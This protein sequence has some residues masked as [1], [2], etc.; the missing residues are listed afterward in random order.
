MSMPRV[1]IASPIRQKPEILRVF[2]DS[3][4]RLHRNELRLSC[5]FIDDNLDPESSNLLSEFDIDGEYR[6]IRA[7]PSDSDDRYFQDEVQHH[8]KEGLVWK[9]AEFKDAFIKIAL[10]SNVDYLFLV[11]SD[12]VLNPR[13]LD[14][15]VRCNKEVISEVFW[16]SWRPEQMLLPQVWVSGTYDFVK[17][18]RDKGLSP[19]EVNRQ[20]IEFLSGLYRPGQRRVGGLGAC[21]LISRS[22]LHKGVSFAEI[23]N[24]T[25]WGEDRHFCV[26]ARALGVE[27]WADTTYPPLHLY[28]E[29]MLCEVEGFLNWSSRDHLSQ[30][31]VTLSMVV[32]NETGRYLERALRHH[33]DAIDAAVIIDDASDD[34]TVKLIREC[35]Q[36]VPLKIVSN[37][38]S[39]FKNEV[40]LR[41]KQ[42]RETIS[43]QPDWILNLDAD[44]ILDDGCVKA[45][46]GI[47]GQTD[48]R[49]VGFPLFD[50]WDQHHYRDDELW[51]AHKKSW[52][53]MF[54][55]TPFFKYK[56][57]DARQH[58]GRYPSNLNF[59]GL[60]SVDLRVRHMGWS[61]ESD[62]L[63]KFKRYGELDPD[64][65]YGSMAQYRSILDSAPHLVPW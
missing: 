31:H 65:Q 56:W 3:I 30:P 28:R 10:E 39:I 20:T 2:L 60:D 42:W 19:E 44:E 12:L 53:L 40:E 22:A 24:L 37:E 45:I 36:G 29:S 26:R 6:V 49:Y 43:T 46:R 61:R 47:A 13:T 33:R 1:L 23:D 63:E 57:K 55:Y 52:G 50:M 64:G 48:F 27:L 34:D 7:R 9:V 8:W 18:D 14:H 62:R 15:L 17:H 38:R 54:R 4:K 59:F 32:R 16:T 21:T 41:A 58:C 11:D 25:Y 35:L 51:A 5:L